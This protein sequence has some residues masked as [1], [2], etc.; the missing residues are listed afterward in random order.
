MLTYAGI[1]ALLGMVGL[2]AG[3]QKQSAAFASN[4]RILTLVV[5][6]FGA[7]IELIGIGLIFNINKEKSELINAELKKRYE[8]N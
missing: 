5:P 7:V 4:V 8:Q 1:A 3:A 6:I 2:V